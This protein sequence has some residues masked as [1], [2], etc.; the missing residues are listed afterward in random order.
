MKSLRTVVAVGLGMAMMLGATPLFADDTP[1]AGS[2]SA[3]EVTSKL[4]AAGYT[5]VHDVE[6]DDGVWEA[7]ATSASGQAV[8]LVIDAKS[9]KVLHERPD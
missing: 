3:A 1:P 7:D 4:T 6:F 9:G 2:L 5:N 8:D